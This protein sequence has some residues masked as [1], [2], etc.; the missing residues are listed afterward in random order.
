MASKERVNEMRNTLMQEAVE[1]IAQMEPNEYDAQ[2]Q[3]FQQ[4]MLVSLA[5][6]KRAQQQ[7]AAAANNGAADKY[8]LRC[9]S[10]DKV[11]P[12]CDCHTYA[13]E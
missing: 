13:Y 9:G 3:R 4:A 7:R 11:L 12:R 8:E 10:C 6:K 1:A 2:I 5:A